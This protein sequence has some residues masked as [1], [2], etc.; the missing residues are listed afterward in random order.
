MHAK[1]TVWTLRIA[2]SLAAAAGLLATPTAVAQSSV[3]AATEPSRLV[4]IDHPGAES[5]NVELTLTAAMFRD[6]AGLGDAA[7]AGVAQGLL[8]SPDGQ[9]PARAVAAEQVARIRDIVRVLEGTVE[10]VRVQVYADPGRSQAASTP[11]VADH[12]T[13]KL[14]ASGWDRIVKVATPRE[15]VVVFAHRQDG[16]LRGLFVVAGKGNELVLVNAACDISP[17]RLKRVTEQLTKVWLELGGDREL[18]RAVERLPR[19]Q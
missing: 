1:S 19:G 14:N 13:N 12:Y 7:L 9:H 15:S 16:A 2:G 11:A 18:E 10:E 8:P 4:P 17:D 3:A 6:L 5:A